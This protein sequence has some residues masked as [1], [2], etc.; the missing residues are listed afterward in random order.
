VSSALAIAAVTAVL[1]DMLDDWLDL[2]SA[3][4][5]L[6]G[7]SATVTAVP[8]DTVPLTGANAGPRL[9]LFLHQVSPNQG[10]RNVGLPSR[11]VRGQRT[12]DP[13]LALDLHYLL[14]AYGP[15]EL[16]AEVLLGYGMQFLH[17]VP[18]LGREAIEDRLPTALEGSGLAR[19]VELI[20]VTP[21]SMSNEELSKLWAAIQAKYRPTAAYRASVVL[22]EADGA[23]RAP[24]P[25]LTRGPVDPATGSDSGVS[26]QPDL[27]RTLPAVSAVRPPNRQPGAVLGDTVVV[28]GHALGGTNRAV[29]VE[30]RQLGVEHEIPALAGSESGTLRFTVPNLPAVLAVGGYMLSAVV[31]RP[32]ETAR[33]ESNRL[34]FTILPR[35]TTAL[36]LTVARDAQG[37]A[38]VD[39]SV[40]PHVRP[41]QRASLVIGDREVLAEDHPTAISGLTFKIADAPPG[42][43][44]VRVR[45]D[46]LETLIVDRTVTP[47]VFLDRR[48]VIT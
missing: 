31:Q 28:D 3:N 40:R 46:G 32:G 35:I 29:R 16:Q 44:L 9:N 36:P 21:E 11:D 4:D 18:V 15:D 22:I 14:T 17:E 10:W 1:R 37:T 2:H 39:L 23:G 25:V 19:Q 48:V 45:V 13:P 24:L 7:A 33:R 34:P 43:H 38:T 47:P 30:S 27:T 5:A 12:G 6:N 41:H 8:P 26:V 20:K 42:E